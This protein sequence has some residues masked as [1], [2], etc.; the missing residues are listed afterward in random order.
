M[1]RNYADRFRCAFARIAAGDAVGLDIKSLLGRD[2]YR[3]RIGSYRAIYRT[4]GE[5]IDVL[6]LDAGPRGD[7]YK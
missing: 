4:E 2:G 7:V 1:P 3:L 6:V 5:H